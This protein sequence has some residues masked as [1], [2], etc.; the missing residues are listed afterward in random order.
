M[1]L[2]SPLT[3]ALRAALASSLP[4]AVVTL[5]LT[6]AVSTRAAAGSAA[7]L[8][9]GWPLALRL[10]DRFGNGIR[11]GFEPRDHHLLQASFHQFFDV[12]EQFFLIDTDQ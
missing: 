2:R 3:T 5:P 6:L 10:A 12:G 8:L 1:P 4:L 9:T 11:I 7:P